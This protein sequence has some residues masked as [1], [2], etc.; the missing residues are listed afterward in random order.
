MVNTHD[1]ED[2]A[3]LEVMLQRQP[4]SYSYIVARRRDDGQVNMQ[5]MYS[6]IQFRPNQLYLK[7]DDDIIFI[8]VTVF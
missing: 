3:F 2:L 6:A 7:I 8:K 5:D 4:G 1:F